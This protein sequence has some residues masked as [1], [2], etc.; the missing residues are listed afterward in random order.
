MKNYP[1]NMILFRENFEII[2]RNYKI[3]RNFRKISKIF[4]K[5]RRLGDFCKTN[6]E[7]F[8]QN[9]DGMLEI[10]RKFLNI[11]D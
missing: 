10:Y 8:A 5:V 9:F 11:L 3:I 6:F 2:L 7:L 1:K 4:G